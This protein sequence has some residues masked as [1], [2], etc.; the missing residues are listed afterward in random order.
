M[1]SYDLKIDVTGATDLPGELCT[2]VTVHLP[3]RADGPL[4]VLFGFPGG[5]F[6]RRYFD[7]QT[8]PGYSQAEYHTNHGFAFVACDHLY[9]G[10]SDQ[11]DM[12]GLTYENLAAANHATVVAV[13]GGLS[14]GT[15]IAGV[16]P[17]EHVAAV[18]MGQSMG[19][20]LLTVQ[21]ANHRTFDGVAFLGWS[22]TFTNFPAP[23]GSRHTYPMPS[24]G[25]DLRPIADQ[26]L[27]RVNPDDSHYR[28]CF[29]WPDEEPELM[30]ADLATFRPYTGMVRGD[31]STPWGS[32]TVPACAITMMTDGAVSAEAAAIDVPV[33]VAG[34]ERDTLPDPWAE[35]TAYRGTWDITVKVVPRMAHMHN[36][37]RT[38]T[39]IWDAI[40]GFARRCPQK[41]AQA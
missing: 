7:I 39:E 20:C 10:D 8:L 40:E 34:G 24:R 4:P 17:I 14:I 12:F 16:P 11:P 9:V 29:H 18:G 25:T 38:R 19:G 32:A 26:V 3:D 15:L 31:E 21:Q 13:L 28:F 37:A 22:G 2:A 41:K 35:P 30:E 33:L 5:G 23:D 27:G 6:G 1:R 36:F